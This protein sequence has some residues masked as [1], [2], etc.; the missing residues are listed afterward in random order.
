LYDI[1]IITI[2]TTT[3]TIIICDNG[4]ST[5]GGYI[6]FAARKLC[7]KAGQPSST[8]EFMVNGCDACKCMEF[9]LLLLQ[10]SHPITVG[11]WIL[12]ALC[13]KP[14]NVI[15]KTTSIF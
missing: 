9:Y 2:T 14:C 13:N 5:L 15:R 11:K 3:T 6:P 7:S 12:G 1:I 10:K 4:Y 8:G